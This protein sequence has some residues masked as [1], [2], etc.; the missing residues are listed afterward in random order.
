M[1][2][3]TS[4]FMLEEKDNE[5]DKLAIIGL[6]EEVIFHGKR[7]SIK[8]NCRIDTGATKSS[9]DINLA[10]E[11]NILISELGFDANK[12][13]IDP[14]MGS[15]GYGLD[16]AYSVIER[17]KLAGLD[18]DNMLNMP[19]ITTVGEEA[20]KAKEAKSDNFPDGWGKLAERSIMW[21]CIT[22]TSVLAAGANL[23]LLYHPESVK[24][25]K[26][27]IERA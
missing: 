23:I 14:N 3:E 19:I 15:V 1:I 20:W 5:K 26:K 2:I 4:I 22:A 6:T 7:S 12:I 24:H 18:G 10:K 11:L 13:L 25:V 9:M 21:E 17:I 16:Y 8:V 27:F